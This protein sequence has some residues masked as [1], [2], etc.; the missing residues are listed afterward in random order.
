MPNA[1]NPIPGRVIPASVIPGT[2][3]KDSAIKAPAVSRGSALSFALLV[4]IISLF[5]QTALADKVVWKKTKLEE[6]GKATAAEVRATGIPWNFSPCVCVTRDERWGR[7]YESFGEDP[8][9]AIKLESIIDGMQGRLGDPSRVLATAKHYAGDGNTQFD[10]A[11][12]EFN[13]GR[14]WYEQRYTIDQGITVTVLGKEPIRGFEPHGKMMIIDEA[15]AV[16]GSTALSTLSLDFRREVS[17]VVHDPGLVKQLIMS[18]QQLS[19]KAGAA[20]AR[21]PGDRIA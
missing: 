16:L 14:P 4:A 11:A 9:I 5:S 1:H 6:I 18:Y 21:L 7:T 3:A 8:S 20:A 10:T 2:V 15:R 17:I 13:V 19:L 12:A